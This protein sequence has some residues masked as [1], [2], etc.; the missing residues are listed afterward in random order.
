MINYNCKTTISGNT[1]SLQVGGAKN[2]YEALHAFQQWMMSEYEL[3]FMCLPV[4][5]SIDPVNIND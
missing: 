1:Y 5:F 2:T 4:G 3:D